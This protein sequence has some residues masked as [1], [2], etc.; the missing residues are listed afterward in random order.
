MHSVTHAPCN[1]YQDQLYACNNFWLMIEAINQSFLV[2][3]K[4]QAK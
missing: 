3:P 1:N 4:L 2:N